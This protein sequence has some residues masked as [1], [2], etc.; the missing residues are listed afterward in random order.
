VYQHVFLRPNPERAVGRLISRPP[1]STSDRHAR[2]AR[3]AVSVNPEPPAFSDRTKNGI[4]S[5]SWN[6]R[7]SVFRL[8]TAESPCSTRPGRP[9]ICPRNE[10]SGPV[11]SR[12]WVNTIKN[13]AARQTKTAKA[14][15]AK[16][17][18]ALTGTPVENHLGDL[19][20]IFD[21]INPGLLGNAK[22]LSRYTKSIFSRLAA[23]TSAISRSRLH[24][25]LSSSAQPLSFSHCDG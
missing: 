23:T 5:S 4:V 13:P 22:Q 15:R 2:H 1:D 21:F 7:T 9:K 16:A 8:F 10:A 25:P 3:P 18:I 14:L 6:V 17:R 24:L 12:N 19:W 11:I 20:S